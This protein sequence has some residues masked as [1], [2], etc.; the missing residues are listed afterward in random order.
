MARY[1]EPTPEQEQGWHAWVASRPPAVRAVA[2]RFQ[3]WELY[4]VKSSGHRVYVAS[5]DEQDDGKVTLKV[6][7]TGQFNAVA[8]ERLVFGIEPDDLEPCEL[9][10]PEEVTGAAMTQDEVDQNIDALRVAA[11]PDLW[12]WGPD[13]KAQ[14]IQ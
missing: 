12:T 3:P 5:F 8:F 2:E 1:F 4:R 11:R 7:V 14:R 6:A 10:A 9:P 13:G